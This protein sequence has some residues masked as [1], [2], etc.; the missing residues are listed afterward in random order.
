MRYEETITRPIYNEKEWPAITGVH[1]VTGDLIDG[2]RVISR[3]HWTSV[4]ETE[5]DARNKAR[6]DNKPIRWRVFT[7]MKIIA[8][9]IEYPE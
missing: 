7:S 9:G 2:M 8:C 6:I 1:G 3:S 4:E 5:R